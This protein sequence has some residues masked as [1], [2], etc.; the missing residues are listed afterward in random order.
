MARDIDA[1][2]MLPKGTIL[3]GNL[4]VDGYLSS[5]GFGNT[6]VVTHTGFDKKRAVKEFFMKGVSERNMETGAVV[7]SNA[8]KI[9][10]L[11]YSAT[12]YSYLF[13]P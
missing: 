13:S 4:R 7:V 6:Y 11:W 8:A 5:G 9:H 3:H 2:S 1:K 10:D 12:S